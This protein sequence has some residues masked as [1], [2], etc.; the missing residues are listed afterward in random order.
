[1]D[2]SRM[3]RGEQR[4]PMA[5]Y[6]SGILLPEREV[7][8][9]ERLL[10]DYLG[11]LE[12]NCD[13]MCAVHIHL[14]SLRQVNRKPNY[15]RIAARSFESLINNFDAALFSLANA[16]MV[17]VCRNVPVRQVDA[18]LYKVRTL[19][20]N[21]PLAAAAESALDDEFTTWYDLFQPNDYQALAAVAGSLATAAERAGN[22]EKKGSMDAPENSPLNPGNLSVINGRLRNTRIADLIHYQPAMR[23]MSEAKGEILFHEHFVS[24]AALQKRIAPGINFFGNI[25]L[26]QY[27]TETLDQRMLAVLGRRNFGKLNGAI[28]LNLNISTII[29][30]GFQN[31]HRKVGGHSGKIVIEMQLVNIFSDTGAFA[32]ARDLLQERGYRVLIDGLSPL[33]LQFFDPGLLRADLVKVIWGPEFVGEVPAGRMVELRDIVDRVGRG[34]IILGRVDSNYAVKWGLSLGVNRFQG[35]YIDRIA[36]A[37]AFKQGA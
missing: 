19:F 2:G 10:L 6:S 30:Q 8:S 9:E 33:S 20:G 32:Y 22:R 5:N 7:L 4:H 31:F 13:G 24:M 23:I 26:F 35:H 37:L 16:D 29:S 12:G 15:I 17:L 3:A 1:M 21:D 27:L 25:W 18:S 14:S 11:R 28:S 36:E 34:N